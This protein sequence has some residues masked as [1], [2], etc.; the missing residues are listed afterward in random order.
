MAQLTFYLKDDL[1]ERLKRQAEHEH[2]TVSAFI[3][4]TIGLRIEGRQWPEEFFELAGSIP[5]LEEPED[6][7]PPGELK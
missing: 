5:E 2:K 3:A 1:A 4:E 6:E 7:P